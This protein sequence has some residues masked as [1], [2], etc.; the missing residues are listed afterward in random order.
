MAAP[1]VEDEEHFLTT[2]FYSLLNVGRE[3]STDEINNAF[4]QLSK[5]YHPDKH[6][7]PNK[8]K[9]AEVMFTKIKKAHEVLNDKH[10][11]TIYDIYGESGLE[12]EGLEVISRTKSP[13]EIIAEYERLQ[14]EREER[15]LQ[16]RTNPKGTVSIAL[17]AT[18]LFDRYGAEPDADYESDINIEISSMSIFQSV[19]CPLTVKDTIL[20]G[21]S[22]MTQNGNGDGTFVTTWRRLTSH[23]GWAEVEIAAG[24]NMNGSIKGFRQLSKR[25]YGTVVGSL[26]STRRGIRPSIVS[27]LAYQFDRG[28][29]GR[30]TFNASTPSSVTSVLSYDNEKNR[31]VF[32]I[33]LGVPNTFISASYCRKFLEDDAKLRVA[34]KFGT[35]GMIGEYGF[36]KK[37]T[38]F[39]ILGATMVVGLPVGVMLR[40][41][42]LR[43]NQTFNFPIYLSES[44][45]PSAVFYGTVVPAAVYFVVK[46]L[47]VNPFLKQ[48]KESEIE[49][50][51]NEHAEKLLQRK[52][53]AQSAVELMSET[54]ER[55]IDTE[56]KRNGLIII[57]G[58]YG[59]L[60]EDTSEANDDGCID[61]TIP[62]QATVKDS[63]LILPDNS[64][65]SCV[66]GFYD[67]CIGEEKSL[68][69]RYKFRNRIHQV[70]L[71]DNEPIRLPQQKHLVKDELPSTSMSYRS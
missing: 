63:K 27:M 42:L 48:Q 41:K 19:E 56:E 46:K 36:E 45:S 24:N 13:A 2:D 49:R 37:I 47:I 34:I 31:A 68:Y 8:K 64:T 16:Q 53:E 39:S 22:L 3:A 29:Q 52:R 15:R 55:I 69:I 10:K 1:R 21:G 4:R 50:K 7:S 5:I 58:L 9:M 43:G 14:R 20:I 44:L 18:D 32:T 23:K 28:L 66:P 65:K 35:L 62:L 11:R 26:Q 61:V 33:Q 71:L 17:N 67:P 57:K 54:V 6:F 59:K 25:C 40:I 70:T 30:M 51:R 60:V 38:Q 12:T